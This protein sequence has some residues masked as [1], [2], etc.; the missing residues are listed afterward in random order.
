MGFARSDHTVMVKTLTAIFESKR[1][2]GWE[3]EGKEYAQSLSQDLSL[4]LVG[5]V[6]TRTV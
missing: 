5:L 2:V 4:R 3:R 6:E 1:D